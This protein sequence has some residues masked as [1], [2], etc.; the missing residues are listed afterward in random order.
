MKQSFKG[1]VVNRVLP[2]LHGGS[3]KIT[4]TVPLENNLVL[5]TLF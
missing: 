1:T 2:S 4:H 3:L 5:L